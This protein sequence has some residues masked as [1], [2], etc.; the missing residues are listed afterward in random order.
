VTPGTRERLAEVD[1][2]KA[3]GIL[4]VPGIHALRAAWRPDASPAE[5]WLLYITGFAVPGFFLASGVLYASHERVPWA[6]TRRRIVRLLVPYLVA[7]GAAEV[8]WAV[9]GGELP[10]P[11][12]LALDVVF[13]RAFGIYYFVPILLLFVAFTPLLARLPAAMCLG[14]LALALATELLYVGPLANSAEV[15]WLVRNPLRWWGYYLLGWVLGLGHERVSASV[16]RHRTALVTAAAVAFGAAVFALAKP[17]SP[18]AAR[19][20]TWLGN[21]AALAL[22]VVLA[23]GRLRVPAPVRALAEWTYPIY[24]F[25]F[26]FVVPVLTAVPAP[27]RVFAP[28]R[29]VAAWAAGLAGSLAVVALGR[30]LLGSRS[31]LWLG[32]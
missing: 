4:V 8:F 21:H 32:A 3:V 12:G 23:I 15:Y 16:V 30:R 6:T 11:A 17:P 20:L 28:G 2:I 9:R 22:L 7:T 18:G 29:I 26:F 1:W 10:T 13:G 25:H 19:L 31:R 14:L 5:Q 24:L 27:T